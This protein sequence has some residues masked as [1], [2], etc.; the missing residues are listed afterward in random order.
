MDIKSNKK[1]LSIVET[2]ARNGFI[3]VYAGGCVR[4]HLLNLEPHDIDIATDATPDQI[5][6]LFEKTVAVGK[7]FGVIVVI[8]DGEEFE[9]ATFRKDSESSDGRH[10]DSVTFTSMEEDAKRRDLT[11]NGLFYDPMADKV[12]DFVDGVRDINRGVIRLIGDPDKRVE[13]DRLR[14]LR[15]IRFA[16]RL[17]FGIDHY[18]YRT[19]MNHAH[20]IMTVSRER[21]A[22]EMTKILR[23]E[24]T[25]VAF[26][27]LDQT[28]LLKAIL[29][30]ISAMIGCEQPPEFHP[31]G[32]VYTHTMLALSLLEDNASDTL[33]WGTLLHDVGKP[34]TQTFEDRIRFSGHDGVGT[35][36][37]EEILRRFKFSNDFI[38]HVCALVENHMK[39]SA[40]EKMRV[41][42]LKRFFALPK[43]DEHMELHR[44]DCESSHGGTEH[45][46]FV[47]EKLKT[48][49]A[50]PEEVTVAKLPRIFTGH[51]LIEMGYV[52]GPIFRDILTD[53]EDHQL[54]GTI[55]TKEQAIAYVKETYTVRG[56]FV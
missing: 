24:N 32:D 36:I 48:Y 28:G 37:A 47:K 16:A 50:T 3:A 5:E 15:V 14:L 6:T 40:A 18:T 54:E 17:N 33:L 45:Y 49:E 11:I 9:V 27:Y 4:D 43:F 2:L 56:D 23:V 53:V 42:K 44:V 8:L 20:M 29:P 12:Y 51:D 52:V 25:T 19:V 10:P 41:S 22:D 1:A 55:T 13:E 21:I 39:F 26:E 30:E 35:K 31:E 7:A 38:E 46:E 34:P